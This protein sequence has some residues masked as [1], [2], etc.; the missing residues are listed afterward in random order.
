MAESRRW[1]SDVNLSPQ[2]W[3][4]GRS[5][6]NS[7]T[8]HFKGQKDR[9]PLY[10]TYWICLQVLS[11]IML[12]KL[13]RILIFFLLHLR[14]IFKIY[15]E[16]LPLSCSIDIITG[17]DTLS[18]ESTWDLVM[19]KITWAAN[20]LPGHFSGHN[21]SFGAYYSLPQYGA[22]FCPSLMTVRH[23]RIN[24]DE[25]QYNIYIYG[26]LQVWEGAASGAKGPLLYLVIFGSCYTEI[27]VV[28]SKTLHRNLCCP[29]TYHTV[30]LW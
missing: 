12:N 4:A 11:K 18:N 2:Q 19:C 24:R 5:A 15:F 26:I 6:V 7:F 3:Q 21:V 20:N 22:T 14:V 23:C 28:K 17:C 27:K 16:S 1:P 8:V 25:C 10:R 30:S 13:L 9:K 29:L